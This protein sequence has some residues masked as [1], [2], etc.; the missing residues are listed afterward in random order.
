MKKNIINLA[1]ALLGSTMLMFG[2]SEDLPSYSDLKVDKTEVFIKADGE[3][4]TAIVNITEG[5]GNYNVTVADENVATATLNGDEITINGLNNGATT[6]TVTD[7]SKHS[8]VIKVNVKEDF[9]LTLDQTELVMTKATKPIEVNIIAGNG[10]YQVESSDSEVATAELISEGKVKVTAVGN[11]SATIKV[12][13]ADGKKASLN[14]TVCDQLILEKESEIMAVN[15]TLNIAITTGSGEYTVTSDNVNVATAV[16]SESGDAIVITGVSKGEAK[17]TVT[18]KWNFSASIAIKV[19]DEFELEKT[20]ITLLD[21]ET[22]QTIK[23]LKGSEDYTISTTSE[24]LKCVISDDKSA[25]ILSGIEKKMAFNQTVTVKDNKL[26]KTLEIKVKEVNYKPDAYGCAR[27]L[28]NGSFGIPNDSKFELK[29]GRDYLTVGTKSGAKYI[30][31]YVLSFEGNRL[32]H[33]VKDNPTLYRLDSDG[34][35]VEKINIDF[36]EVYKTETD[37]DGKGKYWI[38]F[39]VDD[40]INYSQSYIITETK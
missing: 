40:G 16:V 30:N 25:L 38:R 18:D 32:I 13:D 39:Y 28:I 33:G 36:L 31:G 34:N 4:P 8:A 17:I 35:E 12:T 29:K 22:P 3:N 23:I 11:G 7:W 37:T 5:N 26:D 20:T 10:G 6:V 21:I 1:G 27:W 14:V 9:E 2:C 15:G 24:S 19:V